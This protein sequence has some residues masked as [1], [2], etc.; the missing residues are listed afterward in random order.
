MKKILQFLLLV[1]TCSIA[2]HS[3]GALTS[4]TLQYDDLNRL[5]GVDYG[6]GIAIHYNYDEAGNITLVTAQGNH[7]PVAQ[8]GT[9]STNEDT[10]VSA[11]L[12]GSDADGDPLTFSIVTNGTIGSA[13]ITN[14]ATGAF[15]YTPNLNKVGADSFTFRVS[16]GKQQ[17]NLATV[18][19]TISAVESY[20]TVPNVMGMAQAQAT[21]V[22]NTAGLG[23]GIVTMANSSTVPLG[24]VVSQNPAAGTTVLDTTLV[25]FSISKGP[26]ADT[27]VYENPSDGAKYGWSVFYGDPAGAKISNVYDDT[28]GRR[29]ISLNGAGLT[30]GYQLQNP[31]GTPWNDTDHRLL[32]WWMQFGEDFSIQVD[33]DTT[34]G[35]RTLVYDALDYDQLG[36]SSTVHHGLG[37]DARD[38]K[39]RVF[40]RHLQEDLSEAQPGVTITAVNGI[41]IYGSG[42]IGEVNLTAG[43]IIKVPAEQPTIQ[44][45]IDMAYDGDVVLVAPGTYTGAGNKNLALYGKQVL[46][47]GEK[48]PVSTIIDCQFAGRGF[49]IRHNE[50]EKTIISGFTVANGKVD[51]DPV[52]IDPILA[53]GGGMLI[54]NAAPLL[55]DCV[56]SA[57]QAEYGGGIFLDYSDTLN[58]LYCTLSQNTAITSG[59]GMYISFSYPRITNCFIGQNL[60]VFGA[61]VMTES[62]LPTFSNTTITDNGNANTKRGGGILNYASGLT[63][64]NCTLSTNSAQLGGGFCNENVSLATTL[65]ESSFTGNTATISGGGVYTASSMLAIQQCTLSSNIAES[66]A[67]LFIENASPRI[68]DTI[69]SKNGNTST[70][71][72]G[73]IALLNSGASITGCT[74]TGNK[75]GWGA[76]M[77]IY[78]SSV[79]VTNCQLTQNVASYSE[80]G[81]SGGGLYFY[82]S[83]AAAINSCTVSGNSGAITGGGATFEDST[84]AITNSIFWGDT[85]NE[86]YNYDTTAPVVSYSDV[87]GGFAGTGNIN[88]N[89]LF[90]GSGNYHLTSTSPCIN[91]GTATGA[92]GTD[93]DK[94]ARP[95]GSAF[96]MGADEYLNLTV[97]MPVAEFTTNE[98]FG[99]SPL[100]ISFSNTST[101][102]ITS[103][104]WNFGDGT[105]STQQHPVHTYNAPG[106]YTVTL[107]VNGP[108]GS[109]TITK[110]QYIVV[111]SNTAPSAKNSTLQLNE[112]GVGTGTLQATDVEGNGLTFTLV[113]NGSKGTATITNQATG[114]FSYTPA[115]NVSGTDTF[116]FKVNDGTVDSNTATVTVT[117]TA[118]NDPPVALNGSLTLVEDT[119]APGQL[120]AT[121]S[122]GDA[123]TYALVGNGTKGT[124]SITSAANGTFVYQPHANATGV[125]SFTFKANDSVNDSNLATVTVTIINVNAAPT[126]NGGSFSTTQ[127]IPLSGVLSAADADGNALTY[128]MVTNG[129]KGTAVITKPATGAFTYTPLV[130]ASGTDS[131]TFRVYDGVVYSNTATITVT[132]RLDSDYDGISD[133]VE[134]A[135]CSK[136]NDADSDDD[137][138]LDGLEDANHDGSWDAGET[139]ACNPDTDGDG[140]QDGY[141]LGYTLANVGSNTDLTI[142]TPDEDPATTTDPLVNLPAIM[143]IIDMLLLD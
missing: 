84:P 34:A 15:T 141:E 23:V 38:G 88:A 12:S 123:L 18:K 89:P 108:A 92:P 87:Q 135:S 14:P 125:D 103:W 118:A 32:T 72:G 73:G 21:T 53:S 8:D 59:G 40:A 28:L 67:G 129:S 95:Q 131:F 116:T 7:P 76:G 16:D 98:T 117:I 85:P 75:S 44:A 1:L 91:T 19:V 50:T 93:I 5:I 29:V 114:A 101:G 132:I 136:F 31:D 127:N 104:A 6:N 110:N 134:N 119:S 48:G 9:I 90:V 41:L 69:F 63:L 33:V 11:I 137:G 111:T 102:T 3:F 79:V 126:A 27:I 128:S 143:A 70:I 96:D 55:H 35:H 68:S 113:S 49:H 97:V 106:F 94:H 26:S 13:V 81:G 74:L 121:D 2:A 54:C 130:S 78:T 82:K 109:N 51:T 65:T 25:S 64:T 10:P 46:L 133:V 37:P 142:F 45:G 86:F 39:W 66:G 52:D 60:A 77:A 42:R 58:M 17:S 99:T 62:S 20:V 124:V 4:Q 24:A 83:S 105:T 112:D 120:H 115:A 138:I 57:N 56:F 107:T 22:I 47:L 43:R 80:G 61:G 140:M 36:N 139:D 100:P 30:N 122:E 71:T